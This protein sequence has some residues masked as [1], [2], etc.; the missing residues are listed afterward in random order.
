[1]SFDLKGYRKAL[2][3]A[4]LIRMGLSLG[5]ALGLVAIWWIGGIAPLSPEQS[6]LW[7]RVREAQVHVMEWRKSRGSIISSDDDPWGCGLIG[8]EWSPLSTTLGS[9]PSKRTACDPAWSLAALRWFADLGL[10]RGD[11]VVVFSSSSFPGMML[12]VL[13]AA[14]AMGLDLSLVVSLGSSTWGCNDPLSP[15]PTLAGEL[16]AAGFL[17]TRA[18][19]YTRGGGEEIG[20]GVPPEGLA[21]META[22]LSDGVP[23]SNFNSLKEVIEW[24]MGL[25]DR[26]RPKVVVSIGGSS[27]NMGDDP[28]ALSLPPGPLSPGRA[29]GG[30]GVI[31]LAL[32]AGY[33]VIHI[34]NL[35]DLALQEGIPFDAPPSTMGANRSV[36][37]SLIGVVFGGVMLSLFKRFDGER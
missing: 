13:M 11:P 34:L 6:R 1:M 35:R 26:L 10:G 7:L 27:A 9:L 19:A 17:H 23:L 8:L 16:R 21:I 28:L 31:G 15:W 24:K 3:R 33:P 30:D 18:M 32:R 12:N 37:Y 2:G 22:A 4:R 36:V 29:D 20:G 14:E 25:I 5:M